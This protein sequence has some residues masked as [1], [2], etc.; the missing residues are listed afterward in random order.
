MRTKSRLTWPLAL[1][2]LTS[3]T[4]LHPGARP[5]SHARTLRMDASHS[6]S[7]LVFPTERQSFLSRQLWDCAQEFTLALGKLTSVYLRS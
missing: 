7:H 5:S 2:L 3:G 4:A 6:S 1:L